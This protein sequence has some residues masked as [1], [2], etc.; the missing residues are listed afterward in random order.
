MGGG[1]RDH[2]SRSRV[3][4]CI[5]GVDAMQHRGGHDRGMAKVRAAPCGQ[6]PEGAVFPA[7]EN[8]GKTPENKEAS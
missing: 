4:A 7:A 1:A 5:G 3:E 8:Q 2:K 6:A